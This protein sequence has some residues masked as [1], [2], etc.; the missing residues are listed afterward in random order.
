MV[1]DVSNTALG[2][3][4][5]VGVKLAEGVAGAQNAVELDKTVVVFVAFVWLNEADGS[6]AFVRD[7]PGGDEVELVELVPLTLTT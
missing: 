5:L 2:E 1:S 4:P 6:D 3:E 7:T